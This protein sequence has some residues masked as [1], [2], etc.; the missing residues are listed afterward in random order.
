[1]LTTGSTFGDKKEET[2]MS[3]GKTDFLYQWALNRHPDNP[4]LHAVSGTWES[5]WFG[6]HGKA[7]Q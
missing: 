6:D 5:E 4:V 2:M 1:M 3:K 7:K